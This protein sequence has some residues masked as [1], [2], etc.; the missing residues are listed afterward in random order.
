MWYKSITF[1]LFWSKSL[2]FL[3]NLVGES[4]CMQIIFHSHCN[5]LDTLHELQTLETNNLQSVLLSMLLILFHFVSL[6]LNPKNILN[7]LKHTSNYRVTPTSIFSRKS[8]SRVAN[9][10]LSSV[11]YKNPSASQN[12][13]YRPMSLSTI[14]PIDYLSAI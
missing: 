2:Y 12:C 1:F 4:I 13:S 8:D 14:E 5:K 11:C 6:A 10:C 3:G 7:N 9:V